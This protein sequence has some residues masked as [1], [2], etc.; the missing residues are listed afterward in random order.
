MYNILALVGE[1]GSGKDTILRHL[2]DDTKH[3]YKGKLPL[4]EI[5]SYTSRPPREKEVDGVNYHFITAEKFTEMILQNQMFEA[6]VFNEWC[7]GT[8]IESVKENAINI[9]VFN[10]EGAETLLHDKRV[11]LVIV[12][13]NANDKIRLIRQL[14]REVNP[15]IDEIIRRYKADKIDFEDVDDLCNWLYVNNTPAELECIYKDLALFLTRWSEHPDT[16]Y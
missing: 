12:Y 16:T 9:G 7:Y 3:Y 1:A 6:T 2:I 5:V 10:P 8:G 14:N 4:H 13:I 15:D 11:N